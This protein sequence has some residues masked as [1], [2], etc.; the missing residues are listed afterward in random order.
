MLECAPSWAF[1]GGGK[2][3]AFRGWRQEPRGAAPGHLICQDGSQPGDPVG[4]SMMGGP[5]A[6]DRYSQR[7]SMTC[8]TKAHDLYSRAKKAS[9]SSVA[10]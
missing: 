1:R 7:V 6:R 10:G 4:S 5:R 8:G 3:H 9:Q 2:A